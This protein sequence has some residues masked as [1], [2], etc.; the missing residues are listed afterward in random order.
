M[1]DKAP[2]LNR[3]YREL[4]KE[5]LRGDYVP[6]HQLDL[7]EIRVRHKASDTPVRNA[8]NRLVG[9]GLL[10]NTSHGGYYLPH[11]TEDHVRDLIG[12]SLRELILGTEEAEVVGRTIAPLPSNLAHGNVLVTTEALFREIAKSGGERARRTMEHVNDE[13]HA[14]RLAEPLLIDDLQ[15][16]LEGL[17]KACAAKDW[18]ILRER[19]KDYHLLRLQL[20]PR[21]VTVLYADRGGVE[22]A[23]DEARENYQ[24]RR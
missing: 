2:T 24:Y 19:L 13:L 15:V 20:V 12:F 7:S 5:V 22:G 17:I 11:V 3:V 9:E 10:K 4:R 16:E 23:S 1:K 21:L 6:G 8:V 14:I 18:Q